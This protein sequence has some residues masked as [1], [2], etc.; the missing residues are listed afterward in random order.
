MYD[1]CVTPGPAPELELQTKVRE[2]SEDFTNHG[3]LVER[4]PINTFTFKNLLRHYA[5]WVTKH[6]K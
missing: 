4:A 3:E 2:D 5:K 6:G 1:S